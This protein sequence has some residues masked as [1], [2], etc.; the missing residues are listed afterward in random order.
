MR[1]WLSAALGVLFCVQASA[2]AFAQE[3]AAPETPDLSALEP[4]SN[5]EQ[6]PGAPDPGPSPMHPPPTLADFVAESMV[7]E[8]AL[9]PSGR[10][11]AYVHRADSVSYLVVSDMDDL[12]SKPVVRR[13][14]EVIVYG[15]KWINDDRLIYS[16]GSNKF[17]IDIKRDKIVFTGVPR[18][19]ASNRDLKDTLMFFQNDKRIEQANIILT[20]DIN[21]LNGDSDHFVVPLRVGRRLDLVRI[22]AND[23]QWTT[24]AGGSDR[25]IDWFVD[26]SGRP[27]MRYDANRRFTE[28]NVMVPQFRDNGN[29]DW[30]QAFSMRMDR[31]KKQTQ[32]F[33]PVGPGPQPGFYYVIGRP[34]GADRAGIHL[35]NIATQQ[36]ASE[37]FT[38]ETVDIDGALVDTAT[39]IFIGAMY[40]KDTLEMSFVE[41]R[42]QRHFD[43]LR[44]FFENERSIT[45]VDRSADQQTWLIRTDGPRDPGTLHVYSMT[46]QHSEFI[47]TEN[48]KLTPDRLG[49]TEVIVYKARDGLEIRSYLTLPPHLAEDEKPPLIVVPHGGPE[50]RDAMTYDAVVQFLATRG[51]AVF[52][53]NFRGSSGYGKAFIDAGNRQFGGAMQADIFDGVQLLIDQGRV[54]ASRMC[55][56]GESYGGY[57]A[58]ISAVQFPDLYRCAA[59][60]AGLSDLDRQLRWE[61]EEEGR[62]SESYKYW[63]TKIGDPD[64]DK[65]AIAA[66]SPVR[67]LDAIRIPVL[68]LHGTKDDTVPFEQSQL[69]HD[70]LEKA[71]KPV[72]LVV[73]EDAGHNLRD[74]TLEAYL[75]QLEDF[76]GKHLGPAASD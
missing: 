75:T 10:Y 76:F 53:P 32:D 14:G 38:H 62:D 43:G 41:G 59:S 72:K 71:G 8:A 49:K 36:Y 17:G 34:A 57:A 4:A 73:F 60:S 50:A 29:I 47:A 31:G 54:D 20:S 26:R 58:L 2:S 11:I 67:H 69:M 6:K 48:P 70:A 33:T 63:V 39:G 52:Q 30:K 55:I 16:A 22:N 24:I 3:V 65:A 35:Y 12:K 15:L 40:W 23:G 25:T 61:R 64:R 9:A 21:L 68:L 27:A 1:V 44:D 42:L 37:V 18:L 45:V 19:F 46:K 28:V 51:Y 66:A 74:R 13:L 7:G 56:F 5:G